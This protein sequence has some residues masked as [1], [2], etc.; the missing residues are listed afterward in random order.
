MNVG[1]SI[2]EFRIQKNLSQIAFSKKCGISQTSI[3][4]IENGIK[5]PNTG[6]L[7]KICKVLEIP[8]IMLYL[9]GLEESDI[10]EGKKDIYKVFS[11][12]IKDL[13]KKVTA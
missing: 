10:P 3:S 11:P 9:N 8:E 12:V 6:S 2:K 1:A 5:R 13:I 7:K 4:Q